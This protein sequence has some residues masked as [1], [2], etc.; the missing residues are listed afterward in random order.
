MHRTYADTMRKNRLLTLLLNITVLFQAIAVPTD[1]QSTIEMLQHNL[2][3]ARTPRDSIKILYDIYDLSL[4]TP[5]IEVGKDLFEVAKRAGDVSAQLDIL[6]LN[7]NAYK[8]K[9]DL[10]R[11][12]KMASALPAS[13]E[14]KE[15]VLFLRMKQIATSAQSMSAEDQLKELTRLTTNIK[16]TSAGKQN[17]YERLYNLF[18]ITS[19]LRNHSDSRLLTQYVDT[20]VNLVHKNSYQLYALNNIVHSE[21]AR[22]YSDAGMHEQAIKADRHMLKIIGG[23]QKKYEAAG[24]KYRNYDQSLF[25]VYRRMLRNY[26][27]LT[28]AETDQIYNAIQ[29]L[30]KRDGDIRHT[31]GLDARGVEPY[32]LMARNRYAEAIPLI[33]SYIAAE[34]SMPRKRQLYEMLQTAARQAGDTETLTEALTGY[35][36]LITRMDSLDA[37]QKYKELQVAYDVSALTERN[38]QLRAENAEA[39]SRQLRQKMSMA[40]VAWVVI[41]ILLVILLFLWTRYRSSLSLLTKFA[42]N[43]TTQRNAIQN[44]RFGDYGPVSDTPKKL[45]KPRDT[46]KLIHSVLSDIVYISALG[47]D[48]RMKHLSTINVGK[49][50]NSVSEINARECAPGATLVITPPDPDFKIT[51]D[52]ECLTYMLTHICLFAQKHSTDA[53]AKIRVVHQAGY[54]QYHIVITHEGDRIT[55][56]NEESLFDDIIN[57]DE[58]AERPD[59]SLFICRLIAFLMQS[60]I[61][62]NP[63][64][65]GPAQLII[66]MSVKLSEM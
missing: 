22:I 30:S 31:L 15:T 24:R 28:P 41:A 42:R 32:Y 44:D 18:A 21:A 55:R 33:K 16:Q 36:A 51:T 35:N 52:V 38:A 14:Q 47:R 6:R 17:P 19:L 65:D 48:D 43:L 58:L 26:K 3:E 63:H 46:E 2:A 29:T 9:A 25:V 11:L 54:S 56:G 20:L 57:M 64:S 34:T 53:S 39:E 10:I 7:S 61:A 23:L 37:A 66:T 1:A 4:I 12:V 13:R 50:L 49:V 5:R 40:I 59:S 62:Y 8:D 45:L 27:A 60:S